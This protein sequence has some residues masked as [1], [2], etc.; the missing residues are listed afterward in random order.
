MKLN[1]GMLMPLTQF[2]IN[3]VLVEILKNYILLYS[4]PLNDNSLQ[5]YIFSIGTLT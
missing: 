1:T 3:N 4:F 2:E 5:F